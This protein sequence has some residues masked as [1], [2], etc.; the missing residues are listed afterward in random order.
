M[1]VTFTM[2]KLLYADYMVVQL[3]VLIKLV[4][5]WKQ[6]N[7][8]YQDGKQLQFD[9]K[10]KKQDISIMMTQEPKSEAYLE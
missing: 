4:V 9:G 6:S 3:T 1:R 10:L 2:P 7:I 8:G 5:G